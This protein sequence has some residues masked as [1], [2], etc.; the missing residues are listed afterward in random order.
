V[1][2]RRWDA[3]GN[4]HCACVHT[5]SLTATW[6]WGGELDRW[7]LHNRRLG[8]VSGALDG[9]ASEEGSSNSL[10]DCSPS[11]LATQPFDLLPALSGAET[12]AFSGCD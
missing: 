10:A 12:V 3:P 7:R 11:E 4:T 9:L 8:D 2:L 5:Q 6:W 1:W